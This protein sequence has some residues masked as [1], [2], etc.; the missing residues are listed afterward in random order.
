MC[1]LSENSWKSNGDSMSVETISIEDIDLSVRAVNALRRIGVRTVGQMM[2]YDEERLFQVRN[3][4]QKSVKE[5]LAKIEEYKK[6]EADGWIPK[7]PERKHSSEDMQTW[8]TSE[9]GKAQILQWL[10][11]KQIRIDALELLSA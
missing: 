4:G 3:L 9:T 2:D 10:R 8:Q 7:E 5:I 11:E 6:K 1:S